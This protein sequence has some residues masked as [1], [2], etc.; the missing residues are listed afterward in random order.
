MSVGSLLLALFL[1]VCTTTASS[2]ASNYAIILDSSRYWFNYRHAANAL[3]IYQLL[4]SNGF[5]DDH[6]ILMIADEYAVN[7]RNVI[8]NEIRSDGV[9]TLF[10]S[11]TEIDY[12]GDDVTVESLLRV[13]TGRQE[14]GLP[15][16][17]SD[18]NSNVLIYWTGHGGDRFF[19]WQDVEELM[20]QHWA[21]VLL[22]VQYKEL[23]FIADTCQAFTLGDRFDI[24]PNVTMIGS[25]QRDQSSYA[26]HAD[27][28]IGMSVIERYTY[29][30]DRWVKQ[31]L[32]DD[33]DKWYKTP[34]NASLVEPYPYQQQ[35][36]QVG[37]RE[38]TASH[39]AD[40]AS[41][42]DFFVNIEAYREQKRQGQHSWYVADRSEQEWTFPA[43]HISMSIPRRN[44][45]E[46]K[47]DVIVYSVY[48]SDYRGFGI[49]LV[50]SLG[51][52]VLAGLRW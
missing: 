9:N 21:N 23:L 27:P 50:L 29:A 1:F 52:L 15:V 7:A 22:Q 30:V 47:S 16:L 41:I 19:K 34:I 8:K 4:K 44:T 28:E 10:D 35:G 17:N 11:D 39:N 40:Q 18:T 36:A 2:H 49:L 14:A 38:D 46:T 33:W 48:P 26:H 31:N 6:I 42:G 20:A 12:R 3:T 13:V 43:D 45:T 51:S 32:G 24:V 5:P 25:S 37:I